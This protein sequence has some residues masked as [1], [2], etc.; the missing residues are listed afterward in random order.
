MQHCYADHQGH[1]ES[2]Q[3]TSHNALYLAQQA[4]RSCCIYLTRFEIL[5]SLH[6]T[7]LVVI[8]VFQAAAHWVVIWRHAAITP[9]T[10]VAEVVVPPT[11]KRPLRGV[12]IEA[13]SALVCPPCS[14]SRQQPLSAG[15]RCSSACPSACTIDM[16][17]TASDHLLAEKRMGCWCS[18]AATLPL[19]LPTQR[20]YVSDDF[21]DGQTP[22]RSQHIFRLHNA[23]GSVHALVVTAVMHIH[24]MHVKVMH[25]VSRRQAWLVQLLQRLVTA[26]DGL[27]TSTGNKFRLH[28]RPVHV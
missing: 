17:C 12:F 2:E 26:S 24:P 25:L 13:G 21:T 9:A 23:I 4:L 15:T 10:I 6:L 14:I 19:L 5:Q 3:S 20:N 28:A 1:E 11:P 7:I 8:T 27:R 22:W 16:Q 18:T